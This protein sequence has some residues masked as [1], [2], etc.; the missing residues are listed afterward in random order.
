MRRSAAAVIALMALI[1]AGCGG[2]S[3]QDQLT[4]IIKAYGQDPTKL[5]TT[6]ATPEMLQQ[7]FGSKAACLSAAQQPAAKD[8]NVRV[9]SVKIKGNTAVV[10]R[11]SEAPQ[12]KGSK[13][14]V[15]FV[16]VNGQ[17]RIRLVLP[18]S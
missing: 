12:G 2:T 1:P 9:A 3:P 4:Q 7:Q 11:I 15:L 13:A 18:A 17:W 6:Y 16:K 14:D 5:C 10:R 8:P